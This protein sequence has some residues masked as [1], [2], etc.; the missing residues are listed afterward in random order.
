MRDHLESYNLMAAYENYETSG[1]E[2]VLLEVQYQS[3]RK[4]NVMLE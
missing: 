4:H 2:K 1:Y 3:A